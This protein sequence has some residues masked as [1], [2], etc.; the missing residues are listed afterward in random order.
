MSTHVPTA[1]LPDLAF[2]SIT[3]NCVITVD[4]AAYCDS[5]ETDGFV[6][7]WEDLP[8][9]SLAHDQ[10][11]TCG[12]ARSGAFYCQRP[13]FSRYTPFGDELTFTSANAVCGITLRKELYCRSE[14]TDPVRVGGNLE[15]LTVTVSGSHSCAI[16]TTGRAHCWGQGGEGQLGTGS[17]EDAADPVP[18]AGDFRWA[19]ID[20]GLSYTCGLTVDAAAYCWGAGFSLQLGTGSR[21][22][23]VS[24]AA[25]RGDLK[26]RSISASVDHS[27]AVTIH[28]VGYCWGSNSSGE[29]GI[30]VDGS[31]L[32]GQSSGS[33]LEP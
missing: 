14:F 5:L 9:V 27:C 22:D 7:V 11:E 25:V 24:P 16:D 33:P 26:F 8:V 28:G 21:S 23:R 15:F 12:L 4:G 6:R 18:V 3:A 1:M 20:A 32:P 30:E 29:L 10:Y 31:S 17:R 2:E 19:S 13:G